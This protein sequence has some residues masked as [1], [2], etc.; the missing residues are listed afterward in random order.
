MS[1]YD[2]KCICIS[3][4]ATHYSQK[5]YT[6]EQL[7]D[8]AKK[9]ELN[10]EML[11]INQ[12]HVTENGMLTTGEATM[13]ANKALQYANMHPEKIDELVYISE[14]MGDYLYMDTSKTVLRNIQGRTDEEVYTYDICRGNSGTIGVIK[15]VSNQL[16]SNKRISTALISSA[17]LWE[18]HSKDRWLGATFLGDG[19]GAIILQ[20]RKGHN[21]ILSIECD[22][23][24]D[25]NLVSGF[26]FG[27]T[28]YDLPKEALEK[29]EFYYGIMNDRHLQR[30]M[31]NIVSKCIN[32]GYKALEKVGLSLDD[33]NCIG[34][35]GFSKKF[36]EEILHAFSDVDKVIDP[37]SEKGFLGSVGVIEV[38][39]KFINDDRY[40]QGAVM[41]AISNGIDSNVESIIIRK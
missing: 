1:I 22:S 13:A 7:I 40:M 38:L 17:L 15:M 24:S 6:I 26:K 32:V 5:T 4:V 25:C 10:V 31:E 11:G 12:V 3:A 34:I 30:V 28:K 29:G 39:D 16:V 33:I 41:L 8:K 23:I 35:A 18:N 37:L 19:A 14:G 20:E 2:N 21:E 27:G 36:N 9:Y